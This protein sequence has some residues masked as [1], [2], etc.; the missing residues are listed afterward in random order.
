MGAADS[1]LRNLLLPLR[2]PAFLIAQVLDGQPHQPLHPSHQQLSP[3]ALQRIRLVLGQPDLAHR[4]Q[5]VLPRRRHLHPHADQDPRDDLA[6]HVLS[7]AE[8]QHQREEGVLRAVRLRLHD[9]RGLQG[10]ADRDQ[11]QPRHRG[12]QLSPQDAHPPHA[13]RYV[14]THHRQA[15]RPQVQ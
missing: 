14:Q 3:K 9:R 13:R 4:P 2:L 7:P 15:L 11:H 5:G 10:V 1:K 6:V 8:D 12:V